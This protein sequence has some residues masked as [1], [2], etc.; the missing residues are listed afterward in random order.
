MHTCALTEA[1]G[2]SCWG[3]NT[4]GQLGNGT[5][6]DSLVPADVPGLGAG[7]AALSSGWAH[8]CA[9]TKTG[10]VKCW[11]RNS[12]GQ[13]GNGTTADSDVPV[14]VVGLSSGVTSIAAG[15]LHTCA[16]TG[17]GVLKCWGGNASGQLG[18]GSNQNRTVPVDALGLDGLVTMMDVGAGHTCAADS[19][20]VKCWGWNTDGQ[21]GNGATLDSRVPVAV[22]GLPP[23]VIALSAGDSHTCALMD[24][25][26]IVCWG[27]NASGQLGDGTRLGRTTPVRVVSFPGE[28][29]EVAAGGAHTCARSA[30]GGAVLCWGDNLYGQSGNGAYGNNTL[31]VQVSGLTESVRIIAAGYSHSCALTAAGDMR[32]WGW[33]ADGQL[34]DGSNR[35]SR[36]PVSVSGWNRNI[37]DVAVGW[38]GLCVVAEEGAV[39]CRGGN[40]YGQLGNGTNT[41]AF[42]AVRADL[43]GRTA[44]S[45]TVGGGHACAI[46]DGGGVVCWGQNDHG[47]L[48]DGT[49]SDRNSPVPV[50]G[51]DQGW[52]EVVTGSLHTCALSTLG[53]VKCWGYN[54]HGELGDGSTAESTKPV[55]VS[56]LPSGVGAL[57]AGGGHT[58]ALL[59][60]GGVRCW[61]WNKY[62]QLGDGTLEDRAEPVD[63]GGL[64]KDITLLALGG[65]HSCVMR[66]GGGLKCWGWNAFGQLG[67]STP[68]DRAAPVDVRWLA[69]RPVSVAAGYDFT[70]ALMLGGNL[71]CWGNN[72]SGQLG[73]GTNEVHP[74]PVDVVGLGQK[75]VS[76]TAKFNTACALT[77]GNSL[78]CWGGNQKGQLG[79]GTTADRNQP[80]EV[81][82]P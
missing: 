64:P 74:T 44:A 48:G 17:T 24:S 12:K 6:V 27:A 77:A 15:Y 36:V 76:V 71:R 9:L 1:G 34:G 62:G 72:V 69:G 16:L 79:D 65:Y 52:A 41:D 35:T 51:L 40:S 8:T 63:V 66:S 29:A 7:V 50:K 11:G 45:V 33:N 18:D 78:F 49:T 37:T 73:D 21:L 55:D 13:L 54:A 30:A 57:A 53:A 61:G 47:Q 32:C 82:F 5:R 19:G 43:D 25:G 4:F 58:C 23:D 67:D 68:T 42:E 39:F 75:M 70:C 60:G 28:A 38:T 31:P 2:V 59:K 3:D 22:N 81:R 80:V 14:D 26:S 10:G 46:V 56:G 20:G